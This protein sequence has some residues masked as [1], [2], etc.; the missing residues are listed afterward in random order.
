M[1]SEGAWIV[2]EGVDHLR[3]ELRN[4]LDLKLMFLILGQLIPFLR[5]VKYM[6]SEG[7]Q[8]GL[9][10]IRNLVQFIAVNCR[11]SEERTHSLFT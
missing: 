7:N 8:S 5:Y 3:L 9:R 10:N 2:P 11:E 1:K 6:G 4:C